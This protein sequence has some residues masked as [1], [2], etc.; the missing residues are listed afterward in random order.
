MKVVL[1]VIVMETSDLESV[2]EVRLVGRVSRAGVER[3]L[4]S[5][6]FVVGVGLAVRRVPREGQVEAVRV[7]V[8]A[9][10]V[11]AWSEELR[12]IASALSVDD[13]VEVRGALR[14]R[15]YRAGGAVASRYEVEA[16]SLVVLRS[17]TVGVAG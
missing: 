16:E 1:E 7:G 9:I 3:E 13:V 6:T 8:D 10:D 4:P 15:F 5:G 14:R 11:A 2:N 12:G 17:G